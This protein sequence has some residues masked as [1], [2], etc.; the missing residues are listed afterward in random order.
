MS[1]VVETNP[2][3]AQPLE[4]WVMVSLADVVLVERSPIR[5]AEDQPV[6]SILRSQSEP[7][8]LPPLPQLAQ[9]VHDLNWQRNGTAG[10]VRLRLS[11]LRI[12]P[13]LLEGLLDGESALF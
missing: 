5:Q 11:E 7:L 2:G 13:R 6:V 9:S 10:P 3:E 1:K 4:P 12:W 8:F